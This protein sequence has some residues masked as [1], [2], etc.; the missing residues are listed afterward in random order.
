MTSAV[1]AEALNQFFAQWEGE[2]QPVPII[3]GAE[4]DRVFLRLTVGRRHLRP[5]GYISGPTQM[6]L[7]DQA[8]YAAV[9]TRTGIVPMALTS[10]L[11]IHF[12]R[13]CQGQAVLCEAEILK[14]GRASIL[15]ECAVRAEGADKLVS[16]ATVTYVL[17]RT[18]EA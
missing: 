4:K 16:H 7:V 17:P 12:L 1:T 5:G 11:N 8:A 2:G 10:N 3:T 14:F 9:F 15:I 18:D 13:P 6:A